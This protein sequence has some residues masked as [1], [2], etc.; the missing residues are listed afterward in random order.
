MYIHLISK[1]LFQIFIFY[2]LKILKFVLTIKHYDS[3]FSNLQFLILSIF[4]YFVKYCRHS[5]FFYIAEFDLII[6]LLKSDLLNYFGSK[7]L[8]FY[9]IFSIFSPLLVLSIFFSFFLHLIS[10]IF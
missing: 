1:S 4:C 8:S 10:F 5:L 6:F 3:Y 7:T 9:Y 2:L